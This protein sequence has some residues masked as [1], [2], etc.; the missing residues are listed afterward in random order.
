MSV[1]LESKQKKWL[2]LIGCPCTK[3]K[4]SDMCLPNIFTYENECSKSYMGD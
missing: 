3:T 1:V 2:K 4:T